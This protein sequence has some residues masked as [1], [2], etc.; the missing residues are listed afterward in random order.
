MRFL[1]LL[2]LT[3]PALAQTPSRSKAAFCADRSDVRFVKGLVRFDQNL[4]AFGNQGGIV[5]GG[6]CWWHSRFQRSA[7]YLTYYS[8]KKP[9]PSQAEA[10]TIIRNLRNQNTVLE[11][12]GF[13]SFAEFS[14][15]YSMEIQAE[16][17]RWQRF[18]ALHGTWVRGLRGRPVVTSEFM[19]SL[20]NELYHE[21]EVR[22]NIAYQKL[23]I[24]GPTAHAW[25]VVNMRKTALGY[26]LEV[27]DSN[28]PNST[29]F[30][31]YTFGDSHLS[32]DYYGPF[33]PYLEMTNE[34][35][36]ISA[37]IQKFCD[38]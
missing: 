8:P 5:G 21:V 12:P 28:F 14:A 19:R 22:G 27:V 30:Y 24:K 13:K 29:N 20:M 17:E 9:Y 1:L 38:R 26:V 34:S 10:I 35:D 23:Q 37:T 16:L 3:L 36:R 2:L 32:H 25:L 11:I 6:V 7:L 31:E 4:M 33:T 15:A 18:E